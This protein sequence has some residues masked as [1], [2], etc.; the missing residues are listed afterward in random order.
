MTENHGNPILQ[1][2]IDAKA[3]F[4]SLSISNQSSVHVLKYFP[5]LAFHSNTI[6]SQLNLIEV[7]LESSSLI[8][9]TLP[10]FSTVSLTKPINSNLF[11]P[12]F[13]C[14]QETF[15][16]KSRPGAVINDRGTVIALHFQ[17]IFFLWSQ[18]P[19]QAQGVGEWIDF[20]AEK[21]IA[22]D[23]P[24]K[25]ETADAITMYHGF[26]KPRQPFSLRN[27]SRSNVSGFVYQDFSVFDNPNE[28]PGLVC[29]T[30]ILPPCRPFNNLAIQTFTYKVRDKKFKKKEIKLSIVEG[31]VAPCAWWN[32]TCKILV[33]VVSNSLLIL[34]RQL[35]IIQRLSLTEVIPDQ[36]LSSFAW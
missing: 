28:G 35:K 30:A 33:L 21:I 18:I 24:S 23:L 7:P 20:T 36:I 34:T 17:R 10:D 25:E 13:V 29:L 26:N 14:K 5:F 19:D 27:Y 32:K 4:F 16:S 1:Q 12:F 9:R 3:S 11:Q 6:N 15:I 8:Q 2:K 31:D 22:T